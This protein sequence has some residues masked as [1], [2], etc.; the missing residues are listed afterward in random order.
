MAI[1]VDNIA[2]LPTVM[3]I[4]V[5][6]LFG[7][8]AIDDTQVRNTLAEGRRSDGITAQQWFYYGF[9]TLA[10]VGVFFVRRRRVPLSPLLAAPLAVAATVATTFA[11][12]RYRLA[13]DVAL[14]TLAAVGL[15]GAA[16]WVLAALRGEQPPQATEATETAG[17]VAGS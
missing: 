11:I 15:V 4:R 5:G 7:V 10:V 6:R 14:L 9:V 12:F 2:R 16:T 17:D 1:T 3:A 8:Y 13:A